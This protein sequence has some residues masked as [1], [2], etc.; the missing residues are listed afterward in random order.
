MTHSLKTL[1]AAAAAVAAM[2]MA[3]AGNDASKDKNPDAQTSGTTPAP[4]ASG[5]IGP[6]QAGGG[7]TGGSGAGTGAAD[8]SS[9]M[10]GSGTSGS[11]SGSSSMDSSSSGSTTRGPASTTGQS[12]E[13]EGPRGG[14][15]ASDQTQPTGSTK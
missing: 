13:T 12:A 10:S 5:P 14:P 7:A 1:V 8:S 11:S 2:G 4:D 3:H 15:P 9:G 6:G